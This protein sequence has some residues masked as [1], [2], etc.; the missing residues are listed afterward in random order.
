MSDA[1]P[2]VA[3]TEHRA[4]RS[5]TEPC[6]WDGIDVLKYKETGTHFKDITRQ[7]LFEPGDDISTQL[8]YFEIAPGGHST[9]ERHQH[10]HEVMIIRGTGQVLVGEELRTVQQHELIRIEPMTWHQFQASL[11]APLGFLCLVNCERDRPQR[12]DEKQIAEL[13]AHPVIGDFMKL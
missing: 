5:E 9:F 3:P 10:V 2:T 13:Q 6:R 1:I 8:R 4:F 11:G 12:P 7:V